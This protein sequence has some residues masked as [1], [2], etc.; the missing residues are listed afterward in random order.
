MMVQFSLITTLRL[1][2][3]TII[4]WSLLMAAMAVPYVFAGVVVSLALTRSPFPVNQVY[5]VDMLG[6]ALGCASVVLVLNLLDG[7]SA[8]IFSGAVAALAAACFAASGTGLAG[9]RKR[10]VWTTGVLAVLTLFNTAVP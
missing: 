2:A 9:P 5:G 3:S 1:T 10:A 6:A 7:P 8:M 4:S